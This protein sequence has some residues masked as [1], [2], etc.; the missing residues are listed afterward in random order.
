MSKSLQ[1]AGEHIALTLPA[2]VRLDRF[3][4]EA[5]DDA[6]EFSRSRIQKLIDAHSISGI[7]ENKRKAS[8]RAKTDIPIVIHL[9]PKTPA[10]LQPFAAVIPILYQD[11]HLAVVHKPAGMTVHP[12]AGTG[13]DT[14][15]HALLGSI[16]RLA[17]DAERPG[18]VHRL[19]RETEGLMVVAKTAEARTALTRLFAERQ[20]HKEYA[21]LVWGSVT[22]PETIEGFIARDRR[23]RKKMRFSLESPCE[24]I[25]ARAAALAILEQERYKYATLLKIE[26]ITG[27]TH[28][29]RA[30]GVYFNAPVI[31]DTLY[32]NDA[33]KFRLYKMGGDRRKKIEQGGLLLLAQ[34]LRFKHPLKRKNLEFTLPLPERFK[35]AIA[36]VE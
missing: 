7:P 30:T 35:T 36:A 11:E 5:L 18:I 10:Q 20:I 21:T 33:A 22:L 8:F 17:P 3:L 31:G 23:S 13:D 19:D 32:G 6:N 16:D 24:A 15:V 26:L 4:T 12:G 25:F 29:I 9:P 14:L 2:G 27:R 1:A 28:Q 34:T